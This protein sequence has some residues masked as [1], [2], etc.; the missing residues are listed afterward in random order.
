MTTQTLVPH[1][2]AEKLK[3]SVI[4]IL[5]PYKKGLLG[6]SKGDVNET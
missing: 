4:K 5:L 3:T 1:K 6:Y 2:K